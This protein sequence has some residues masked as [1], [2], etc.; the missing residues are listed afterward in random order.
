MAIKIPRNNQKK[1]PFQVEKKLPLVPIGHK[2]NKILKKNVKN[3]GSD[4]FLN[5]SKIIEKINIIKYIV[6]KIPVSEIN[7]KN[8]L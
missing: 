2:Y 5:F 1:D 7:S 4:I 3:L 8:I 6:P